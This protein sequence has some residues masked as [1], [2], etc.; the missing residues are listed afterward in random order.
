MAGCL[1]A[2]MI[3]TGIVIVPKN[4]EAANEPKNVH[5]ATVAEYSMVDYWSPSEKKAPVKDGYVF[6]GWYNADQKTPLIEE[7]LSEADKTAVAKF[8]PAEVLSIKT[9]VGTADG[10]TAL[11]I[12]STVDSTKYQEVGF[13]YKLAIQGEGQT[14]KITKVYS[15]IKQS[16]DSDKTYEPGETF[17]SGVSQYFIAADVTN[18]QPG[19]FAKIVYARPFW[20]TLDGTKVMGLARNSRVEDKENN[21]QYTSV[22]INLLTDGK[23]MAKV[24]A[25][26]IQITYNTA[27]YDVYAVDKTVDNLNGGKYLFPEMECRIDDK[28]GTIT[29]VGNAVDV[30]ENLTADGLFAN[31]RF[32]KAEG[33][34]GTALDF[35]INTKVTD[36]CNWAEDIVP[37]TDFVVQ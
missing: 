30:T 25:G 22:G 16:K 4:A 27:N 6:G 37:T 8:V 18:I 3:L 10:K 35:A 13:A 17:V 33:A 19:S 31:V 24:A 11:R 23:A 9:Q 12:L 1:A 15:K 28:A 2:A 34:T 32:K 7:N 5:F 26:K 36:F 21:D 14:Q 29:F 20:I